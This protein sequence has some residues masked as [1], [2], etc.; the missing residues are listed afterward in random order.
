MLCWIRFRNVSIN[1]GFNKGIYFLKAKSW[2]RAKKSMI[3]LKQGVHLAPWFIL[4]CHLPLYGTS[5]LGK[6]ANPSIGPRKT[7]SEPKIIIVPKRKQNSKTR[8]DIPKGY[9]NQLEW[10]LIGQIRPIKVSKSVMT[11][12]DYS[13]YVKYRGVL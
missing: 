6:L 8:E 11:V 12:I 7:H 13:I 9:R 4:K 2:E 3:P 10:A 1:L 5:M